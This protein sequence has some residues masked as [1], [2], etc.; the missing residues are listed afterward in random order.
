MNFCRDY[1]SFRPFRLK[2]LSQS[3]VWSSSTELCGRMPKPIVGLE[4]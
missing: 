3:F 1:F 2:K 4:D